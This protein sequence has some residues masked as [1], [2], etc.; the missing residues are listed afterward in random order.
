MKFSAA[1]SAKGSV[2]YEYGFVQVIDFFHKRR[3]ESRKKMR[4]R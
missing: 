1:V 3:K 2:F 4:S